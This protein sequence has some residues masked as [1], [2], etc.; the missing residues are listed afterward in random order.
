[1]VAA[2]ERAHA[3][4]TMRR[5]FDDSV[6]IFEFQKACRGPLTNSQILERRLLLT[7]KYYIQYLE[8][9][10]GNRF[11]A[12]DRAEIFYDLVGVARQVEV[13]PTAT[14]DHDCSVRCNLSAPR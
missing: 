1:M 4:H 6:S 13:T 14:E 3:R 2:A 10:F 7:F 8:N 11:K 5:E 12:F 9:P